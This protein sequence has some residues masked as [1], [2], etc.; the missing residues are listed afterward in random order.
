M[1]VI[2]VEWV[3]SFAFKGWFSSE[4]ADTDLYLIKTVGYVVKE[5]KKALVISHSFGDN[6]N[7]MDPLSIPKVAIKKR[8]WVKL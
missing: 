6:K 2:Y 8:K 3:D 1:K 5:T 7:V 4:G